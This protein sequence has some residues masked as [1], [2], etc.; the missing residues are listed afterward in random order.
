LAKRQKS[1]PKSPKSQRSAGSPRSPRPSKEATHI[2]EPSDGSEA[3]G[4]EGPRG[5]R[6]PSR[7][8]CV[9]RG[10]KRNARCAACLFAAPTTA[11]SCHQGT[12]QTVL[13]GHTSAWNNEETPAYPSWVSRSAQIT[14]RANTSRMR[15]TRYAEQPATTALQNMDKGNGDITNPQH[16]HAF[17]HEAQPAV[18]Q[19]GV[20]TPAVRT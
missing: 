2:A 11:S 9:S 6:G 12:L 13:A 16:I 20:A 19:L 15:S 17:S 8:W 14:R 10:S 7:V 1:R 5:V 4:E 3:T 18:A